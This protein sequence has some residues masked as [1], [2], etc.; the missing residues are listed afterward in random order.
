MK[1]RELF[2]MQGITRDSKQILPEKSYRARR[3]KFIN[4]FEVNV[5]TLDNAL[6]KRAPRYNIHP[7]R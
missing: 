6:Q 4:I 5:I 7:M 3:Q 1:T 2:H